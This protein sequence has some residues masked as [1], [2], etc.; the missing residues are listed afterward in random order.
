MTL[1][2]NRPT[3]AKLAKINSAL[4]F[5]GDF[6]LQG[7]DDGLQIADIL[8]PKTPEFV[9]QLVCPGAQNDVLLRGAL[10]LLSGASQGRQP[11]YRRQL[12]EHGRLGPCPGTGL[13]DETCL[14]LGGVWSAS[15]HRGHIWTDEITRGFEVLAVSR[16][17]SVRPRGLPER[18]GPGAAVHPMTLHAGRFVDCVR[19]GWASCHTPPGKRVVGG[20]R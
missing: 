15:W 19:E 11:A 18:A 1:L 4:A 12:R 2:A 13:L 20:R 14:V 10:A 9:G 6:A 16:R 17:W 7:N 5:W 8:N 3:S